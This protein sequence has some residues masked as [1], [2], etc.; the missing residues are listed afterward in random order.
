MRLHY[1][2][3][4]LHS[5]GTFTRI[6][7]V[8]LSLVFNTIHQNSPA[9][10]ARLQLSVD[11]KLPDRQ[12]AAGEAGRNHIQHLSGRYRRPSGMCALPPLLF[13]L[14]TNDHTG[15]PLDGFRG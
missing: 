5:P 4:H 13:S 6:L 3:Q 9:H 10:C 12:E 15:D 7:F 11:H 14:Y 2:L 8:D 1:I